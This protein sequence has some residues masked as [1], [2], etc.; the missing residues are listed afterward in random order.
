MAAHLYD[1]A[2]ILAAV[3]IMLAM[4]YIDERGGK[5]RW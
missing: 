1:L 5:G 3:L 4:A 2:L